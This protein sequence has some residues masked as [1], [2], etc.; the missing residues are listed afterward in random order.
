LHRNAAQHA[1]QAQ[2]RD[3]AED[4]RAFEEFADGQ[5]PLDIDAATWVARGRNGLDAHGEA[6]LR[7]W[8]DADPR[9]RAA[10]D[11]MDGTFGRL[12]D[13]P[14]AQVQALKTGLRAHEAPS[15][16][17]RTPQPVRAPSSTTRPASPGRRAWMRDIGRFFP[18]AATAA[19][20]A[21]VVGGGWF[22]WDR[23]R[24]QPTFEQALRHR[25]RPA[26]RGAGC[27]TIRCA[28]VRCSFDTA[29]RLEARLFRDRREVRLQ[30]GQAHV[31]RSMP[32]PHGPS[33]CSGRPTAHH[34]GRHPLLRAAHEQ[35]AWTRAGPWSRSRRG[36]C[37]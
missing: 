4:A 9:H 24:H 25:T 7:D 36:M 3:E 20:A 28:A 6:E 12:R 1:A 31:Q 30:D 22:G 33:T 35:R 34:G 23:W 8:L 2:A 10:Y 15:T 19:V 29:T 13:M 32:T 18:Q 5:D 27:P 21:S 16:S 14:A 17:P 37:A 26:D 11:D